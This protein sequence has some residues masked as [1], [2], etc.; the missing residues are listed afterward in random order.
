MGGQR[1]DGLAK[2]GIQISQLART[3][4][5]HEESSSGTQKIP[6][7]SLETANVRSQIVAP[8]SYGRDN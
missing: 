5:S 3:C 1:L 2:R 4:Q 6:C 7:S 8:G